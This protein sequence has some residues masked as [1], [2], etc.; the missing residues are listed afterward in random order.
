MT[1]VGR[2]IVI[3]GLPGAGKSTTSEL[4]A[5]KFEK[6][7]HVEA[8]RIQELIVSGAE[9]P[10]LHGTSSE[11][12]L[13]LD[14]RLHHSVELAKSFSQSGFTAVVDDI[15][16]G[17]RFVQLVEDLQGE[18]FH[19]IVL[20]RDLEMLKQ[21]WRE[22]KSPFAESWDWIDKDLRENTPRVGLWLDTSKL[23][24]DET[25]EQIFQRLDESLV[26]HYPS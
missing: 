3:T 12:K 13:Q 26:T 17:Y 14:L 7:A 6:S 21:E 9:H 22:M 10:S 19:L 20:L 4:L 15:I 2:I 8:D 23:T 16:H 25:V 11:A 1:T 5:R 18:P 24:L